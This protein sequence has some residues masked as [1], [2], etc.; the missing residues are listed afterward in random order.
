[1][2]RIGIVCAAIVTTVYSVGASVQDTTTSRAT[3]S[4]QNTI[5]VVGC[6]QQGNQMSG[7]TGTTG[8]ATSTT[9]APSSASGSGFI[10]T[11]A[12]ASSTPPSTTTAT[13]SETSTTTGATMSGSGATYVLDGKSE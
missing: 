13:T 3:Q 11:K 6:L 10:L 7:T 4:G 9:T 12:S 2:K 8:S 1:M 5:T